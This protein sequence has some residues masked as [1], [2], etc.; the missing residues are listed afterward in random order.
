MKYRLTE[1]T[2]LYN[3]ITLRRIECTEAFEDVKVGT[4]GGWVEGWYNLSQEGGSWIYDNAKVYQNAKVYG[5][6]KVYDD[7]DVYG[8]ALVYG[9]AKILG[10]SLV[11]GNSEVCGNIQVINKRIYGQLKLS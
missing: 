5:N 10:E 8:D 11:C 3:D 1:E 6:A 7:S 2:M 9:C 4:K